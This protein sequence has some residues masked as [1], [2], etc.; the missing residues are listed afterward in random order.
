MQDNAAL[1][2]QADSQRIINQLQEDLNVENQVDP[3]G[4]PEAGMPP[5][6]VDNGQQGMI[7]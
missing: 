4:A 6:E 7:Q 5:Q 3:E 2:E 1:F